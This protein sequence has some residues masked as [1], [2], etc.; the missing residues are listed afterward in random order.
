MQASA[1]DE[2]AP[3]TGTTGSS[4]GVRDG[5]AHEDVNGNVDA[6]NGGM[7]TTNRRDRIPAHTVSKAYTTITGAAA[8]GHAQKDPTKP[9]FRAVWSLDDK[10]L[11]AELQTRNDHGNHVLIEP[12]GPMTLVAL[13]A[14]L[15]STQ[16]DWQRSPP[17]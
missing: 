10:K 16:A 4:L 12:S 8:K 9:A 3:L 11:P 6:N 13:R 14:A 5:E 2:Q 17:P 1:T 15:A 7:S